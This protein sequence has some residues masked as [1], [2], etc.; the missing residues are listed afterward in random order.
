MN[1]PKINIKQ[2][3][4]KTKINFPTSL[5]RELAEEIG[6]HIG[7]G[8][9]F[10]RKKENHYDYVVCLSGEEESYKDYVIKLVKKIYGILPS[11]IDTDRIKNS[12]NIE[13]NSKLLFLWKKSLGLPV[14]HKNEIIIPKF[15]SNSSF[16]VDC[17]R[18]I[19][20][21]DGSI[22]FKKKN[23]IYHTYPVLKIDNKS[24]KLVLQINSLLKKIGINSSF[25][26]NRPHTSSRGSI[27]HVSTIYISGRSNLIKWFSLVSPKNEIHISKYQIWKKF[28]FCPPKTTLQQRKLILNG[29]LDPQRIY[30]E[31]GI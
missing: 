10:F 9:L 29:K 1:L 14:G 25:E 23:D 28:G 8:S 3:R 2:I 18:G 12:I 26:L 20:D 19:F 24:P 7:D 17:L 13:Y 11:Y 22:T 4:F 31:S 16:V 30:A 5:S 27:T 6:I 21:T 15:I